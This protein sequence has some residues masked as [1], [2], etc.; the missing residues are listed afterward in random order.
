MSALPKTPIEEDPIECIEAHLHGCMFW[1][2]K[3][4]D[5][6]HNQEGRNTV[7]VLENGVGYN[8]FEMR[9]KITKARTSKQDWYLNYSNFKPA[10]G[11]RLI[12][13]YREELS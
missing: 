12:A 5:Y 11:M 7:R 2:G 4:H 6:G 10:E 1:R 13:D 9:N 8:F 3:W